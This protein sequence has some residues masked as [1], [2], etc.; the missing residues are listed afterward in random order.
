MVKYENLKDKIRYR[1]GA[2]ELNKFNR[3]IEDI[4]NYL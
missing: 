1:I 2:E 3:L 4:K